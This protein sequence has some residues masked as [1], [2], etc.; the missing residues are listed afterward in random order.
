MGLRE[1]EGVE[2][3]KEG[4]EFLQTESPERVKRVIK[5]LEGLLL[6]FACTISYHAYA[7]LTVS[8]NVKSRERAR[9]TEVS[10]ERIPDPTVFVDFLFNAS[11]APISPLIS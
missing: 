11:T 3:A 4:G 10:G 1:R 9:G 8:V 5:K 2:K 6:C 7:T